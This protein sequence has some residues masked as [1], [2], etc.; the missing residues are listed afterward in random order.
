MNEITERL[1]SKAM[2]DFM[3]VIEQMAEE[4]CSKDQIVG[5]YQNHMK[6]K[7]GQLYAK[8]HEPKAIGDCLNIF[9]LQKADSKAEAI[10]Y[11]LLQNSGTKFSFQH[12]IGPY[13]VDY[14]V[15]GFLIIEIDGP[16]HDKNH[17]DKRDK[18]L[19]KMGYKIIRIPTWVLVSCPDAAI[20][21]IKEVTKI[22]RVK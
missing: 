7:V 6:H 11:E 22:K 5:A 2:S 3:P 8:Q 9:D 21:E 17:D 15:M 12:N 16:Q 18:Y 10:F 13:R 19:R 14:L 20:Q 4:G 1:H